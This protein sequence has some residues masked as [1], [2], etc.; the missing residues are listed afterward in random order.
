[1]ADEA[2]LLAALLALAGIIALPAI[3]AF[4]QRRISSEASEIANALASF[5]L[6][7]RSSSRCQPL[8]ATLQRRAQRLRIPELAPLLLALELPHASP[9]LLAE[10][11]QR[12]A[13]RLKRRVAFERKMLARTA[14]GRRRGAVA[15]SVA[16]LAFVA[17]RAAGME[18]PFAMFVFLL[19][20]EACGCWM[21][22][23]LARV[24]I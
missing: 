3:M 13:L 14:S 19:L 5:A 1:M 22:W 6:T 9:Q 11:A 23:R 10:T 21:L 16:P 15:A 4:R 17:L 24:E 7:V 20:V 12:L 2:Q 8:D 18:P